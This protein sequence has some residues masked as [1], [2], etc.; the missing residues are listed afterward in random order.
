MRLA[1]DIG[2]SSTDLVVE[3]DD[4]GFR[5]FEAPT[6]PADPA[7]G[8]LAAIV[9]AARELGSS[10]EE[11]LG[12]AELLI[13]GTTRGLN[14]VL[15]G[16]VAR[17]ALVTTRGHPDVL[18]FREGGRT[19]PFNNT[20]R[21]PPPYV[22]RRLTYEVTERIASGQFLRGSDGSMVALEL[23]GD[24]MVGAGERLVSICTGGGGYGS[25]QEREPE[26]VA[27]DMREGWITRARAR[28]AYRVALDAMGAIDPKATRALRAGG[29]S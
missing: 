13:H 17:T 27:E 29:T 23:C 5:L 7:A 26:R 9:L 10:V 16:E 6:V 24:V 18:L 15:T 11:F 3:R 14:A 28:E 19:Q 12:E 25:P 21:Y 8:A 2:G 20:R 4:A 22:P 1:I